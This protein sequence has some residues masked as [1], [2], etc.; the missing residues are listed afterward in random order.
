MVDPGTDVDSLA[1]AL[2]GQPLRNAT[3]PRDVDLA[4]MPGKF[5]EWSVPTDIAFDAAHKAKALF[6]D[7]DEQTFQSWTANGW[8]S[9]RFQQAPGQ[10]DRLWILDVNGER[11][12]VDAY[13]LAETSEEDRAELEEVVQSIRF[14]D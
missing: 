13:Y 11:L 2:A 10:V 1:S 12:V 6:P 5:L 3:S 8:N 4:G 7:C 9:D 14:L